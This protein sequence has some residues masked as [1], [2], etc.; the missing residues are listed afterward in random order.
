MDCRKT[1]RVT[2]KGQIKVR[3]D[4]TRI[5]VTLEEKYPEYADALYHSSRDTDDLKQILSKEGFEKKD[6]KTLSFDI[7]AEY[8]GYHEDGIYRQKLVGYRYRHVMKVDFDSDPERMGRVLY[9]LAH[10]SLTPEI[11]I[12]YTVK[13]REAAKN[14]LLGKAVEDARQKAE[15]L[16]EA[17]GVTLGS[18][19][20]V[21]YSWAEPNFEVRPMNR[22]LMGA[23]GA[24]PMAKTSGYD[25][26]LE[27]DDLEL[28]DTV[29][30]TYEID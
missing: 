14:R 30:L 15:L 6:L 20:N 28:S 7:D 4:Q 2:G 12:S 8:E 21:N 26:N 17:A 18:L 10:G 3:P 24:A 5:T 25:L 19:I 23:N 22:A 13:D 9:A 27:P 11:Q 16:A 29:T 1:I